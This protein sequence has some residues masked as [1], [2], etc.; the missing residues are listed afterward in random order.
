[1]LDTWQDGEIRN[2]QPDMIH[3]TLDI[4]WKV[5]FNHELSEQEAQDIAYILG[6]ST[7]LFENLPQEGFNNKLE[8]Y[9]T[10]KNL[11]HERILQEMDRY[12][13]SLIQRCRESSEDPGDLIS[14]LMQVR[15]EDDN[16]QMS[17]QQLRDEVVSLLFAGQEAVAVVLSW[18]FLLISLHPE[19]Q[20]KL[21]TELNE[22]LSDRCALVADLPHL[23]YTNSIIKEA[24]RLYPL[25]AVM[26]HI[27]TQDYKIDSYKVPTGCTVLMSP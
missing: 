12:I 21:Q 11:R 26:P 3:L 5:I 18:T 14:M 17:D 2:L 6:V 16:T 15:N 8:E 22:V 19:V 23:C 13:Y 20:T 7:R 4:I 10:T 24:M 9:S 25:I 1:M 27:A